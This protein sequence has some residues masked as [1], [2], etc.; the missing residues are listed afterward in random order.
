MVYNPAF[1]G[2]RQIP[3]F[4]VLSRQQWLSW[5]GSPSSNFLMAHTQLRNKNVGLGATLSYDRMGPVQHTGFSGVYA[6]SLKLSETSTV[7]MGLQGELRVQQI[8]L[9]QLQL[10]D[11]G[12]LLFSEDPGMRL[13]PNV[14]FGVNFIFDK[15]SINLAVPRLLNVKLSPFNGEASR[16]SRT[17]RIVYLGTN[18]HYEINEDME[19]IPSILM[20][21]SRGSSFF[22]ELAGT[23]YYRNR[24]GLGTFYRIN[25]TWGIMLKYNHQ[26]QFIFGYSYD[27]SFNVTSYNAGTHELFL[28][29]NFPFNKIKTVS[30]RRF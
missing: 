29:Y 7:C 23:G 20:A 24:F 12:D 14:G 15:Y 25:K 5:E 30:P 9:T 6:Y 18:A 13:Q 22:M 11:Q 17:S 26:D 21:F 19:V 27:V 3:G 10:V 4:S 28:G 1:A 16:W 8:R 2:D